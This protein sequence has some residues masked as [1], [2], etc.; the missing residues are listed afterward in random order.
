MGEEAMTTRLNIVLC[1]GCY[2]LYERPLSDE[3]RCEHSD[4]PEDNLV[5]PTG[6]TPEWCPKMSTVETGAVVTPPPSP[7][8][9][10]AAKYPVKR[11]DVQLIDIP[12]EPVIQQIPN[13]GAK[14][15]E[16]E[17]RESKILYVVEALRWGDREQHSYVV[18]VYDTLE[19]AKNAADEHAQYRGGKYECVVQQCPLNGQVSLDWSEALMYQTGRV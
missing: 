13:L 2:Y 19:S 7:I 18:G 14:L 9:E 17:S 4:A 1:G 6:Y 11:L 10:R 8:E 12:A 5:P 3:M 15:A 16:L